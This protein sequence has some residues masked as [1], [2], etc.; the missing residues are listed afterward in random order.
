MP[1]KLARTGEIPA[2]TEMVQKVGRRAGPAQ[3]LRSGARPARAVHTPSA[4]GPETDRR[5]QKNIGHGAL[6]PSNCRSRGASGVS[7]AKSGN[8]CPF[9]LRCRL[10]GTCER[11]PRQDST[12]RTGIWIGS[13]ALRGGPCEAVNDPDDHRAATGVWKRLGGKSSGAGESHPRN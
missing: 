6:A 13:G 8:G 7:A 2:G 1:A 10:C 9:K 12:A 5:S 11:V 3:F 4:R